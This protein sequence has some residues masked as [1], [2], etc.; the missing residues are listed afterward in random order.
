MRKEKP[1]GRDIAEKAKK[2][3][4]IKDKF[5]EAEKKGKKVKF[6]PAEIP[7]LQSFEELEDGQVIGLLENDLEGD[8][9]KLPKGKHNLFLSKVND[10]WGIYA[11][12]D[13]EIKAE[14]IRVSLNHH[15]LGEHESG[16]PEFHPEGWCIG[17]CIVSFWGFCLLEL[18]FCF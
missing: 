14:A 18:L 4:L 7:P 9:T 5:I 2:T 10:E 17:V 12:E 13:G 16:R 1:T 6:T 8:E 11:E 3:K 15:K